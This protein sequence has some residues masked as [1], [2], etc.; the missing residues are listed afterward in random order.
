MCSYVTAP[1]ADHGIAADLGLVISNAEGFIGKEEVLAEPRPL[2][3]A[4]SIA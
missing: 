1:G 4:P 3:G 2:T